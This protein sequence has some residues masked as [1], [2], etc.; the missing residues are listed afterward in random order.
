MRRDDLRKCEGCGKLTAPEKLTFTPAGQELCMGCHGSFS[1]QTATKKARGAEEHRKCHGCGKV[2]SPD[3]SYSEAENAPPIAIMRHY[4]CSCGKSFTMATLPLVI[5][6]GVISG[7]IALNTGRAWHAGELHDQW[8]LSILL[9]IALAFL[10]RDAW[11]R[12]RNP[13]VR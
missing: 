2:V 10:S 7:V 4:S 13:R 9:A 1:A 3:F 12:V 6:F 5:F 8:P 11:L